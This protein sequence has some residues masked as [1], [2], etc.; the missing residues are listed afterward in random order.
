MRTWLMRALNRLRPRS[1]WSRLVLAGLGLIALVVTFAIRQPAPI[2][3]WD[4]ADGQDRFLRAYTE[5]FAALPTPAETIDVRTDFGIV[6]VYRFAGTGAQGGATSPLL[7][8]PGRASATP[9]WAD[10]MPLLLAIGDVY[11]VDL[12]GE[13]GMSVQ[14]RPIDSDAAQAEWLH[15]TLQ[16]LPPDRFHLVGL[17]IGGWTA[18]NLA[19]HR[20]ERIASMTLIDPVYVFADLPFGTI[21]R[22]IPAALPWLPR[23]WR[24]SFNSYTAGGAPVEDEPVADMIEAG[25]QH[26]KLRLPQP[27]RISE[28]RLRRL[29]LPV[30]AIIAGESVMHDSQSAA[31]T[32]RQT[33][34]RGT[35]RLYP[36]AS[37]AV[38]GEQ[39]ERIAEDIAGF[40]EETA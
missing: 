19:L 7:L 15:Q 23:S 29:D 18:V 13:P 12:L 5:A 20:P 9:V 10:N 33:L 32:A 2:G 21:V 35:V 14:N 3:H 8:L 4:S 1:R 40:V 28:E 11:T 6:R 16:A 39:P 37:H 27:T 24:D 17:S 38:N 22:S 30:L 31:G 36:N 34:P 25:M 26:Y